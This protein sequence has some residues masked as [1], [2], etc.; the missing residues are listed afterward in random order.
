VENAENMIS[1]ILMLLVFNPAV[2]LLCWES[3]WEPLL[4]LCVF[5]HVFVVL[6]L[7]FLFWTIMTVELLH[8]GV[9]AGRV[10]CFF[11]IRRTLSYVAFDL[12]FVT[13]TYMSIFIKGC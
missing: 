4:C 8:V 10:V 11:S 1:L 9:D 2:A 5:Q 12:L 13:K 3:V 6:G 7:F